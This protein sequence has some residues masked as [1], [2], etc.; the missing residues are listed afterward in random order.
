MIM[1]MTVMTVM[2]EGKKKTCYDDDYNDGDD[3]EM[4]MLI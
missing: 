1:V 4:T 2:V 3:A